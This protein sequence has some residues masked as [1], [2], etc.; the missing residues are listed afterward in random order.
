MSTA[1]ILL[2]KGYLSMD[3]IRQAILAY[4]LVCRETKAEFLTLTFEKVNKA[5]RVTIPFLYLTN[6]KVNE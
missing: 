6:H 1:V 4:T 3:E 2:T 5:F